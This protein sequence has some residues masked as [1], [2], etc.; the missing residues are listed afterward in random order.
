MFDERKK[1]LILVSHCNITESE[2]VKGSEYFLNALY[3]VTL[4]R[5][6][7]M[8]T[9]YNLALPNYTKLTKALKTSVSYV[10]FSEVSIMML[11]RASRVSW[12]N[13]P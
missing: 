9:T 2:K 5:H 13:C 7:D 11:N 3:S 12:R 1:E 4:S 10:S 8:I 6:D